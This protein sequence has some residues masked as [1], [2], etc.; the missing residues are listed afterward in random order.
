M[1]F[2]LAVIIA[3]LSAVALPATAPA[4]EIID[5]NV[6][7]VSLQAAA[8]GQALISFNARGKRWN[9]LAWGAMNALQPT[10][11]RKHAYH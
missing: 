11:A 2:R 5:R 1:R 9:V 4:S 6:S 10:I 7:N 3:V 8:N